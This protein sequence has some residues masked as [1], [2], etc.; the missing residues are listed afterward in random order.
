MST[1]GWS[2]K[3]VILGVPDTI[4]EHGTQEELWRDCGIDANSVIETVKKAIS[5]QVGEGVSIL[6]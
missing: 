2:G 1:L 6:A 3:L 5:Q 4:V